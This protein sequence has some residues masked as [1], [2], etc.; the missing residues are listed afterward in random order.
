MD[1]RLS[2]NILIKHKKLPD[3]EFCEKCENLLNQKGLSFTTIYSDKWFFGDLMK[4]SKS[5]SVPQII[6][7]GEF[8]GDFNN[9]I[10]YFKEYNEST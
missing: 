7:N 8:V 3:C 4:V 6:I 10:D 1:I 2:G 9:L 5:Q